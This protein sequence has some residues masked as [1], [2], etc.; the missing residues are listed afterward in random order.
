VILIIESD[1]LEGELHE[2]AHGVGFAGGYNIVAGCS[3]CRMS[4]MA[5]AYS[6]A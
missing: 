2:I 4:H 6:L 5:S 1:V 3:C